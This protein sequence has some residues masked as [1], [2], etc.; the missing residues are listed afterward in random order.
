MDL[1]HILQ[2]LNDAQREAVTAPPGPVLVLAG[3]GSGKTRVLT[4]RIAWLVQAEGISP[5]S[6]LA[7]TF[8]NKA[9]G[10]MRNRIE[11][12]LGTGGGTL[13]IGTFHGIAHRLLR[14][15]SREAGLPQGF[16]ILDS[17][18]Q[19]RLIRKIVKAQDL[20][21]SRWIAREIQW[22]INSN[23]D[24][25]RRPTALKDGNDPTRRQLIRLYAAYEE[26]CKAAGVVDF[27]ELLLRSYELLRD[28]PELLAHYRRRFRHVLV[29]E[30]QDTNAI[31]YTWLKLLVG[32]ESH[33]FVVGDDDQCLAAGTL[34][35]M[36][37]GS[38][39]AIDAIT[40]GDQVMSSYGSGSFRP[41][42]VTEKFATPRQGG[43]VCLH[44][45]SGRR[46]RSTP[47]HTHFAGYVP[48]ETP[49]TYFLYLMYKDGVGYRL[50]T[51]QVY[52]NGQVKPVVGF[53]QRVIPEHAD[54]AWIIRAH[55]TEN[56]A[57]LDE[58]VTSLRYGLPTLPFI[59][60]KGKARNG[61]LHDPECIARVFG[62]LDTQTA[63]H[64]LLNDSGLDPDRP[65]H[66][67]RSRNCSP[68][69]VVITLCGDRRGS[70]PMHCI[71]I[72]GID[73]ADRAV[74]EELGL[75]VRAAK[76]GAR[77]WRFETVR[78]DFGELMMVA[79]R[80]REALGAR[81]VLQ[82][83]ILNR[84]LPFIRAKSI[85]P[86]MVL[87]T[88]TGAFDVV[89]RT[90]YQDVATH[91]FDLNIA[92]THNYIANGIVTHNSIYGWRGA[93][94]ENVR[95]LQRDFPQAKLYRLEQNYRS[96]GTILQGAN[97]LIA[98]NSGRLG[99]NLWTSGAHGAPLHLYAAFNERDEAEFVLRRIEEWARQGGRRSDAAILYRSNA[100][101]RIFEETFISA[102]MPYRVYGGL[103]FFERAE[104]KDALAY[105]RLISN[106]RDDASFERIVNL[107]ARGIGA[108]SID[109]IRERAKTTAT[110][111]W[112]AASALTRAPDA[113][114]ASHEALG[115]KAATAVQGFL[116]LI[117]RLAAEIA[118]CPLHEQVDL[119]LQ[120]CGLVEHHK[121]EKADR[122]EARVENLMELVS[123]ARGFAP[124][125]AEDM[126]PLEAFLAH[127]ALESGEDQ[128]E[129][130]EDCVQLMTLHSAKGLEFPLVFLAGME[131][132]LFP[133]QR[134]IA[135][136][137]AL[138]EERRLCY[139]G[140]TR[141]MRQL[142]LTYAEQ[143]RLHG[144]DSF[145]QA[146]RFIKEV[147]EELI[148]EVRPRV[149][150]S[151]PVSAGRFR[152]EE[153]RAAGMSL[154][155]RVRHGKFGEGVILNLEGNGPHA[156]VQVSFERQGT[157]WLMLQ[158]ANLE[159]M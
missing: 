39:K 132:G 49:Q 84:S 40:P 21:E 143:R 6:V 24:E 106:R 36:A 97:A 15:H 81:Y 43:V 14:L 47:E 45:R 103:R 44:L 118:G 142:Y 90:E 99:K 128:A 138:E 141:A 87:A 57:R 129:A 38:E 56:D 158:Y 54:A 92:R 28:H 25:A 46:I 107:P 86:G 153:P 117:E 37:D 110:S 89:E 67:L 32:S 10:E 112:E 121:R 64:R 154:G 42:V 29:D 131:E 105:L 11:Q 77:S 137:D 101:S 16:Q 18:D 119:M 114:L 122:G 74:L 20:D 55:T 59:P 22:F 94:V 80:I 136:L 124:A 102:R 96:T 147:P 13:W 100:Q 111:L 19:L 17:E 72:V 69:D 27:A 66:A 5:Y 33:L 116:A 30:F 83:R 23:K 31:Q 82:G 98:H 51:S 2:P 1:T 125:S 12:M 126:P 4:H 63:A 34:I 3:A 95:E 133:H 115:P 70:N 130:W 7:V 149:R 35:T 148:E 139:V 26:A 75:S 71:S 41:A 60:R 58:M 157:K 152:L 123:A 151:R 144:I 156:R 76:K 65:H 150:V 146:S 52:T 62:S 104:I 127:A 85:R 91:V 68:R 135:E 155:A 78:G 109:I 108:K 145:G 73:A 120:A 48:G 50:G 9:A 93:R 79:K 134:S 8:T 140:M 88:H 113:A 61:L 53:K 159:P